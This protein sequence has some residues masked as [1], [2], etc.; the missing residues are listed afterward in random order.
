M[1]RPAAVLDTLPVP[2]GVW[3]VRGVSA[4]RDTDRTVGHDAPCPYPSYVDGYSFVCL[5]RSEGVDE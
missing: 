4:C 5:R 3:L 1:P 2:I